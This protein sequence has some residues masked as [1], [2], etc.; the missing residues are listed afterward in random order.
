MTDI[1]RKV[2]I[3]SNVKAESSS[4]RDYINIG[5]K[6]GVKLEWGI[7][8]ARGLNTEALPQAKRLIQ[9]NLAWIAPLSEDQSAVDNAWD[10]KPSFD[11]G[12][13][14]CAMNF[15][16]PNEKLGA[17]LSDDWFG[18]QSFKIKPEPLRYVIDILPNPL[19]PPNPGWKSSPSAGT[20]ISP[21]G[22][23]L[24]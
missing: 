1:F 7:N 14:F 20:P 10:T 21:P 16:N 11:I 8:E 24:P 18:K 12:I 2:I 6:A 13:M 23:T 17:Y 9:Q 4:L 5:P 3:A 22:I 15:W 19:D